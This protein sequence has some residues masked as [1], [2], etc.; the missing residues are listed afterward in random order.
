M[1]RIRI[2]NGKY[3]VLITPDYVNS[4]NFEVLLDNWL[5]TCFNNYY[6][7]EFDNLQDALYYALKFPDIDWYKLVSHHIENYKKLKGILQEIITRFNFSTD[8]KPSITTPE[9]LKNSM[10]D[11]IGLSKKQ[12]N[13][14]FGL[15]DVITFNILNPWS[16]NLDFIAKVFEK[17]N[18]LNIFARHNKD[19]AIYLT[20]KTDIGTSYSI[21]LMPT[22]IYSTLKWLMKNKE[23]TNAENI[24]EHVYNKAMEQQKEIDKNPLVL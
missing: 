4:A 13:T 2:S 1:N 5:D 11:R 17:E 21:V 8:F 22:H 10:F 20:G 16:K 9:E 24:F 7:T 15:N 19:N 3:Q 23:N 14:T 18:K 12:F 6:I